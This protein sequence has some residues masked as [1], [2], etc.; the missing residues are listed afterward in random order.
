MMVR[1]WCYCW[2]SQHQHQHS[3]RPENRWFWKIQISNWHFELILTE[4]QRE[5]RGIPM[6]FQP[7]ATFDGLMQIRIQFRRNYVWNIG[8][9]DFKTYWTYFFLNFENKSFKNVN[10]YCRKRKKKLQ[11]FMFQRTMQRT[12]SAS[13]AGFSLPCPGSSSS[14]PSLS[15]SVFVLRLDEP[16]ICLYPRPILDHRP[17]HP[18]LQPLCLL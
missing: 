17:C 14:S 2:G 13:V 4:L 11:M 7:P 9:A 15:A 6:L 12:A 1:S 18:S 10:W 5:M 16:H 8:G 3:R